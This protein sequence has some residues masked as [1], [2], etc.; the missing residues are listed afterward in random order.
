MVFPWCFTS[1]YLVL[2]QKPPGVILAHAGLLTAEAF[3][4]HFDHRTQVAIDG[5]LADMPHDLHDQVRDK[6]ADAAATAESWWSKAAT[7]DAHVQPA[8]E[9]ND[10]QVAHPGG[11]VAG[12]GTEDEEHP[13][14]CLLL[15]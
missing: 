2:G 10:D 14:F 1:M 11:L 5:W 6:I 15:L 13:A 9:P 3:A 8:A 4:T 7:G 12:L